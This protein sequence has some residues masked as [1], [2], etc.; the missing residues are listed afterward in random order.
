LALAAIEESRGTLTFM[1]LL[2]GLMKALLAFSPFQSKKK[3]V[4]FLL[5]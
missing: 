1:V 3:K 2:S 4:G 5:V